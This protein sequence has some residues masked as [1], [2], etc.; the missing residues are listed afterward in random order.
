MVYLDFKEFVPHDYC[1]Y[2]AARKTY[3]EGSRYHE[4]AGAGWVA[5]EKNQR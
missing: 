4:T 2:N 3:D 1:A 5:T